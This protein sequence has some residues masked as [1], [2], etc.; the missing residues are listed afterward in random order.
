MY[1]HPGKRPWLLVKQADIALPCATQNEVS[2]GEAKGLVAA[3]VR[4]VAEGSNMVRLYNLS[5]EQCIDRLWSFVLGLHP[6]GDQRLRGHSCR[7]CR[8]DR[9]VRSR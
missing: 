9:L 1:S 2:E 8:E 7:G 3:G 5:I 6:R 4:I